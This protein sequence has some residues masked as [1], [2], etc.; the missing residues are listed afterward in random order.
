VLA[1]QRL[2]ATYPMLDTAKLLNESS[3]LMSSHILQ[4]RE[5]VGVIDDLESLF[6]RYYEKYITPDSG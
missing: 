4:G 5:A 2:T 1:I 6:G 3:E